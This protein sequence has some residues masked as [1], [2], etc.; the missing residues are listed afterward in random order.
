MKKKFY[1]ICSVIFI[2]LLIHSCSNPVSSKNTGDISVTINEIGGRN[3]IPDISME[4]VSYEL[5]GNG[6]DGAV[7]NKTITNTSNVTI[8]NLTFGNWTVK[9]NAKNDNGIIIGDGNGSIDVSIGD[10]SDLSITISPIAGVG[11]LE[12][13]INW[14]LNKIHSPEIEATL[15]PQSGSLTD[16]AFSINS[17]IGNGV[18][19]VND[20]ATGY[21][22]LCLKL[23]DN[24]VV[25]FGTVEVLRIVDGETTSGNFDFNNANQ[26]WGGLDVNLITQMDNPLN[27]VILNNVA[28]K[29]VNE[30]ITLT[31]SIDNY[32]DNVSY[33]WYV[34]GTVITFGNSFIFDNSWK[35]GFYDISVVGFSSDGKRGGVAS[36]V[37]EVTTPVISGNYTYTKAIGEDGV[38]DSEKFWD[39]IVTSE[40]GRKV[41]A[42]GGSN[43]GKTYLYISND[44]GVT[45]LEKVDVGY[46]YWGDLDMSKDGMII[47]LGEDNRDGNIVISRDGGDSWTNS[48]TV[49]DDYWKDINFSQDDSKIFACSREGVIV[50]T[51]DLGLTWQDISIPSPSGY[52][53]ISGSNDGSVVACLG[54]GYSLHVTNDGGL[55]WSLKNSVNAHNWTQVLVSHNGSKVYL[56]ANSSKIFESLDSGFSWGEQTEC[57]G[58]GWRGLNYIDQNRIS[59]INGNTFMVYNHNTSSWSSGFNVYSNQVFDVSEDLTTMYSAGWPS[60]IM[61]SSDSGE[62]WFK[63]DSV[64]SSVWRG[65]AVSSN[66]LKMAAVNDY[67]YLHISQDGGTNWS[68]A[69]SLGNKRFHSVAMSGD[70]NVI[71]VGYPALYISSDGGTVFTQVSGVQGYR[72]VMSSN[73]KV[74]ITSNTS[75]VFHKS[76]DGGATW[77][78]MILPHDGTKWNSFDISDDGMKIVM[79]SGYKLVIS[80]DM[81]ESW[82]DLEMASSG[83]WDCVVI[84]GDGQKVIVRGLVSYSLSFRV[85][86]DGGATWVNVNTSLG[87][88][89][90]GAMLLNKDGSRVLSISRSNYSAYLSEDGGLTWAEE[91]SLPK[92]DWLCG[93]MAGDGSKVLVGGFES[94][95]YIGQ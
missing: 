10:S 88:Y 44:A 45:W 2:G 64:G 58:S 37:I 9:V 1:T 46:K 8:K 71:A 81:G 73:G 59:A 49:N 69:E 35:Q 60:H 14:P 20:L 13:S 85:S 93:D 77:N 48:Y 62:S 30:S 6:P 91:T 33:A 67:G 19:T 4:P 53:S 89:S 74:I 18:C 90:S 26:I 78:E 56:T 36:A 84:S 40:D 95:L 27:V 63:L 16:L 92:E 15:T 87:R 7:F 86:S 82:S 43:G 52:Y 31:S 47:V 75:G 51:S 76:V 65:A 25:S 39:K 94:Y 5:S 83:S 57:P 38:S 66:G 61:K 42:L 24:G 22:T 11:T 55:T 21:Y 12:L 29:K 54:T 50:T 23:L 68:K 28:T 70:G 34:N 72:V 32:S 80:N 41:A 3:L 79:L 17:S